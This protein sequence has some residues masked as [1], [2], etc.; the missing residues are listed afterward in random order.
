[1]GQEVGGPGRPGV[2]TGLDEGRMGLD[3]DIPGNGEAW[4]AGVVP[5]WLE[6][7]AGLLQRRPGRLRALAL[8]AP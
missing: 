4:P 5:A 6:G 2:L 1:M 8:T 3:L 7:W